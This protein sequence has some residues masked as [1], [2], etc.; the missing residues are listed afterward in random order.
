MSEIA[1]N[2]V[3]PDNPNDH[4]VD[5]PLASNGK[6]VHKYDDM[7]IHDFEIGPTLGKLY[8][9]GNYKLN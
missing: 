2:D 4:I 1:Y 7:R 8:F 5:L 6:I 3:N 9:I